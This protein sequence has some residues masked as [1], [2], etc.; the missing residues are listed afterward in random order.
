MLFLYHW[1]TAYMQNALSV[2]VLDKGVPCRLSEIYYRTTRGRHRGLISCRRDQ[3]QRVMYGPLDRSD[4]KARRL[5][6]ITRPRPIAAGVPQSANF[7]Y[8]HGLLS[9]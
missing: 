4:Y 8:V 5:I 7:S 1:R 3:S 6:V 2:F 9:L